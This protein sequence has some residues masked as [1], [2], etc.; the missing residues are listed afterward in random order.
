M[1]S[2]C[3]RTGVKG[4]DGCVLRDS[5]EGAGVNIQDSEFT[6]G[7]ALGVRG[8]R[9]S[10]FRLIIVMILD[11]NCFLRTSGVVFRCGLRLN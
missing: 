11:S 8:R 6:S 10:G 2:D 7:L 9:R 3:T 4:V 1:A 5:A